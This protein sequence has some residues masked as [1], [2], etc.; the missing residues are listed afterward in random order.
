MT[1]LIIVTII[2]DC[3]EKDDGDES[4]DANLNV[5]ISKSQ[6]PLSM[7]HEMVVPASLYQERVKR[8]SAA[9]VCFLAEL[10]CPGHVFFEKLGLPPGNLT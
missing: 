6:R 1:I 4:D 7:K 2:D 9:C 3:C 10:G 8:V 5:G